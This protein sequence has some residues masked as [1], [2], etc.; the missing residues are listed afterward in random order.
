MTL[1]TVLL[2]MYT[3][4]NPRVFLHCARGAHFIRQRLSLI[5]F[6]IT[7]PSITETSLANGAL[8][9]IT[10]HYINETILLVDT[11]FCFTLHYVTE[12][13]LIAGGLFCTILHNITE[14]ILVV[15]ASLMFDY[16]KLHRVTERSLVVRVFF[17]ITLDY[18][19]LNKLNHRCFVLNYTA[20]HY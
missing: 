6:C 16:I 13:S 10:L 14:A 8:F 9:Y 18:S 7:L 12:T 17:C 4:V 5:F 11:L 19:A 15:G 1:F 2:I 3:F 20:L